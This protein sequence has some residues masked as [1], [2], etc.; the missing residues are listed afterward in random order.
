MSIDNSGN[1]YVFDAGTTQ[2]IEEGKNRV[3]LINAEIDRLTRLQVS[4]NADVT[5]IHA[6]IEYSKTNLDVLNQ[7]NTDAQAG[8]DALQAKSVEI[9]ASNDAITA[10]IASRTD[11]IAQK[12]AAI[13]EKETAISARDI[14]IVSRETAV[15]ARET[16]IVARETAVTDKENKLKDF[17]ATL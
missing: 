11:A 1:T 12:E 5:N 10:D 17:I 4:L 6:E 7:K 8:F 13:A 15:T 2:A 3:S 9:N 14:D 16:D